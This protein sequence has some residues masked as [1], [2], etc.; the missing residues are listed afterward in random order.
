[1]VKSGPQKNRGASTNTEK[2]IEP[3]RVL[4]VSESHL[5]FKLMGVKMKRTRE[6]VGN[7]PDPTTRPRTQDSY[8][9][10][11]PY[12]RAASDEAHYQAFQ[13]VRTLR[14]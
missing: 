13:L 11:C 1:M 8:P 10:P 3:E 2:H 12:Y 7:Q 14:P 4:K 6:L 9:G 5:S